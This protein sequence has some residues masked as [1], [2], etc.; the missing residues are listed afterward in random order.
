MQEARL[1]GP[2]RLMVDDV[3]SA[4]RG[5]TCG[6]YALGGVRVDGVFAVSFIGASYDELNQDLCEKI[7]TAP[8]FKYKAFADPEVAFLELCKLFHAFHPS[9]NP[10]HPERPKGSRLRCPIC[11]PSVRRPE[12]TARHR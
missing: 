6:V 4:T 3:R 11:D 10:F 1:D 9:G 5:R 8:Y 2:F 12:A 7:G